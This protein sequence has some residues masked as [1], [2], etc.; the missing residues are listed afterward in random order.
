[1]EA[2]LAKGI[3]GVAVSPI[4]AD[5]QTPFSMKFVRIPF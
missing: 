5:N 4:D 1:M 2:M 3:D